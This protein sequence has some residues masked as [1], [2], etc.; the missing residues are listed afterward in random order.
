VIVATALSAEVIREPS[1]PI[2]T[3][4]L[5]SERSQTEKCVKAFDVTY[6]NTI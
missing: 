6:E 3:R 4:F 1:E 2:K 5:L